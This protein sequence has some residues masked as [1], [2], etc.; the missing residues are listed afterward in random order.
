M[1]LEKI[2]EKNGKNIKFKPLQNTRILFVVILYQI[3]LAK[4]ELF[5][6]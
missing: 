6:L 3:K 5:F 1:F 4:V 2:T